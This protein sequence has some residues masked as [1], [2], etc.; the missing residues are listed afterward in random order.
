[1][2]SKLKI[3]VTQEQASDLF[4]RYIYDIIRKYPTLNSPTRLDFGSARIIV[5]DLAEVAPTGSA[6]ANRQTEMMYMLARHI[7]ARNFFLKPD[8]LPYVPSRSANITGAG[9]RRSYESVKRLDYDE[10]HRTQGSPQVRA[11]AE[12]DMREGPQAQYS[13]R[14]S[15]ASACRTWATR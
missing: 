12:L 13:T 8:Y 15:P 10:W 4:E 7:L 5:L 6:A 14:A 11:Q 2:F 9:S 1:M 3:Q